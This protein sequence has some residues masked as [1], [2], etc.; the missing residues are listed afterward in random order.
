MALSLTIPHLGMFPLS[1]LEDFSGLIPIVTKGIGGGKSAEE[2][3]AE[4]EA[5]AVPDALDFAET[6]LNLVFPG[7][8]TGLEVIAWLI[9]NSKGD[10]VV[11][12][13]PGYGP[14]GSVIE[15]PNPDYKETE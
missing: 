14:D 4:L 15:I 13:I 7:S 12:E 6:V 2:I 10:V 5:A 9:S 8:G 1:V 3:K 11:K